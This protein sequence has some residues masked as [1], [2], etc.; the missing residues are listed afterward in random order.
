MKSKLK[1]KDFKLISTQ[2]FLLCLLMAFGSS[3]VFSQCNYVT[4]ET[5]NNKKI[6]IPCDFPVLEKHC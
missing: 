1:T 3:K 4:N 2:V 5:A 6:S